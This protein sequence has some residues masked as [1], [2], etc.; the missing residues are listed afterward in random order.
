MLNPDVLTREMGVMEKCTFCV[1]RI[2]DFKDTKRTQYGLKDSQKIQPDDHKKLSQAL[3]CVKSCPSECISFGNEKDELY[4]ADFL[5]HYNSNRGFAMLGEL[6]AK[7]AVRYLTRMVHTE[8]HLHHGGGHGSDHG[9]HDGEH[10]D[11]HADAHH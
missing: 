11:G 5:K 7:P 2:R 9:D 4:G 6:N 1:Q 8:S 3:P 10:G